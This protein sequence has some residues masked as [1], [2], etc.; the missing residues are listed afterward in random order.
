MLQVYRNATQI[1]SVLAGT[2]SLVIAFFPEMLLFAW[3][4]D[5]SLKDSVA[6]ILR[7][8]V[9]GNAL[10]AV[11]AFPY[12]LQYALGNLR[13][14]LIGNALMLVFLLP[15]IIWAAKN[16]G[17]TGAGYVWLGLNLFYLIVW[18]SYVHNKLMPNFHQQWITK[19]IL[20]IYLP[21]TMC[22]VVLTPL[23]SH[24][25]EDNRLYD[26]IGLVFISLFALFVAIIASD[27]GR[28]KIRKLLFKGNF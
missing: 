7:L 26:L 14:H 6:P 3:T 11:G 21:V 15:S 1:V 4:G 23:Q 19:D 13:Y 17:G 22:L 2:A 28:E 25:P 9:L 12:Y 8:Y 27:M 10:L 18:V 24:I 16:Y 20:F 5:K